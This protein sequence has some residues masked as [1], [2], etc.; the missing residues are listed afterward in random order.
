MHNISGE[1]KGPSGCACLQLSTSGPLRLIR[2]LCQRMRTDLVWMGDLRSISAISHSPRINLI[3]F[4]VC[5][6]CSVYGPAGTLQLLLSPV[7]D[8]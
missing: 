2:T 3:H 7:M 5:S 6:D 4:K 1:R 8:A